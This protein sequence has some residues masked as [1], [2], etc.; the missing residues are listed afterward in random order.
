MEGSRRVRLP[1]LLAGIGLVLIGLLA[2]I[3]VMLVVMNDRLP[4]PARPAVVERVE[5]G[6]RS[7]GAR[8]LPA[9]SSAPVVAADARTLNRLFKEVARRV[10]PAVV[11]IQVEAREDGSERWFHNFDERFGRRSPRQ[12]VGSG[13]IISPQGYVVTNNHVVSGADRITVT[14]SDKR[15]YEAT[16]VGT[17]P[18]TDLAVLQIDPGSSE[19]PVI[20]LGN[21]DE[22]EVGEWVLAVGNP[23]R[24][25]STVTAGIISALGRQVNIIEDSFGIEDFIQT[26]AAINPGNS[27]GALVN[28]AGELVGISTAIATESGSYEGYGFAVPVNLVE[29]VVSDLIAFGEVQRG[30]LGVEISPVDARRA[31]ALGMEHIQGVF[32]SRV[33]RGLAADRAGLRTGDVVLSIDGHEVNAPNELQSA[34]ARRRPGDR[35]DIV[36]WRN[37]TRA[38]FNVELLGRDDPVFENWV[39]ELERQSVPPELAPAPPPGETQHEVTELAPWGLGV[40]ELGARERYVFNV[41]DGLYLAYVTHGSVAAAAGLPRDVVLLDVD[42]RPVASVAEAREAFAQAAERGEPVLLRVL[43]RDGVTA[44]FELDVPE[45]H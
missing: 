13:V 10:T 42:D 4:E 9:D 18:N 32:L 23:F 36:V 2:G 5:L 33:W 12:S 30:Y 31:R 7:P 20:A 14:L 28:L 21:S 29:R 3:L 16:I 38:R 44:F 24:L 26:D 22:V 25:T 43:R 37:G 34:V 39:S 8:Y 6:S 41:E 27:G 45:G 11:Y 40:R 35:L 1:L 17:D 19:L 15:Q